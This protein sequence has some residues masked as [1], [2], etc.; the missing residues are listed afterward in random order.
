MSSDLSPRQ[1]KDIYNN[2]SRRLEMDL[3]VFK[4]DV[5]SDIIKKFQNSFS[6]KGWSGKSWQ[7]RR[8]PY[9]WP[10]MVKTGRLRN[11]I[12]VDRD[13]TSGNDVTITTNSDYAVF[14]NDPRSVGW[15]RNQYTNKRITRRQFMGND[16]EFERKIKDRLASI[17]EESLK[18]VF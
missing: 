2:A 3:S 16:K 1:F 8:R 18:P 4:A 7:P 17:I 11:S 13:N 5:S 6:E 15:R 12:S 9:S 10:I 14:H